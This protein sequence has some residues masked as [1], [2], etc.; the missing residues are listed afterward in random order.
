[1]QN[2]DASEEGFV[3]GRIADAKVGVMGAENF[4]RDDQEFVGDCLFDKCGRRAEVCWRFGECVERA[5][6]CC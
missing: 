1:M 3:A 4:S 6:R 2:L 5:A